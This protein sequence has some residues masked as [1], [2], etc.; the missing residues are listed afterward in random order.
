MDGAAVKCSKAQ[1]PT[2]GQVHGADF[3]Y[4]AV[5]TFSCLKGFHLETFIQSINQSIN[6]TGRIERFSSGRF[7]VT[8]VSAGREVEWS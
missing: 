1:S 4:G 2:N 3:T 7:D 6:Q 5:V 8:E